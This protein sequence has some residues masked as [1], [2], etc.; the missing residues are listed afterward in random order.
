MV[1]N[2]RQV[3]LIFDPRG[4]A[5]GDSFSVFD[6]LN[7]YGEQLKIQCPLNFLE[8]IVFSGRESE[9]TKYKLLKFVRI[10]FVVKTSINFLY[11][12][13]YSYKLARSLKLQIKLLVTTDPW[14]SYL[15]AFLLKKLLRKDIPIQ[16]QVHGDIGNPNWR[17]TN[18]KNKLRFYI[19]RYSL[20]KADSIRTVSARQTKYL[21]DSFDLNSEVFSII[22]VPISKNSYSDIFSVNR[23]RSIG[24]IGRIH[25]ERGLNEFIVLIKK[26]NSISNDFSVVIAGIGPN[27]NQFLREV[28]KILPAT[29]LVYLGS[30]PNEG[31]SKVWRGI[32]VLVSLAPIESY[33]MAMREALVSGIPVWATESSGVRDLIDSPEN[34]IVRLLDVEKNAIYL[35]QEFDQLVKIRVNPEFRK[36]FIKEN[37][38]YAAKLAKS[39]INTINKSK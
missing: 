31:M 16:I 23:Q 22:P 14:E 24:F 36:K 21:I 9:Y 3:V 39:W 25:K 34:D 2:K 33:G 32:G 8:L 10:Y 27:T 4:I 17:T 29:R 30:V 38:T 26:L 11:F 15:G 7:Q 35:H 28:N 1:T 13:F 19:A 12:S 18:A 20:P 37:N 5:G 6:R